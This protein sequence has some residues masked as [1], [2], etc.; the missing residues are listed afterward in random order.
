[1]N[2]VEGLKQ[3]TRVEINSRAPATLEEAITAAITYDTARFGP[4]NALAYSSQR[5][6]NEGHPQTNHHRSRPQ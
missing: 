2:F 1:M 5:Q 3:A 6:W 4:G